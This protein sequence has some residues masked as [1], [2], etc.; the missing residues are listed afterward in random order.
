MTDKKTSYI[1][2][3][4]DN[5]KFKVNEI[6]MERFRSNSGSPIFCDKELKFIGCDSLNTVFSTRDTVIN[7]AKFM[8]TYPKK[9]LSTYIEIKP[10]TNKLYLQLGIIFD[11]K[12]LIDELIKNIGKIEDVR[13]A[14][15]MVYFS[16]V[17]CMGYFYGIQSLMKCAPDKDAILK[18][19][20]SDECNIQEIWISDLMEIYDKYSK[21]GVKQS[22]THIYSLDNDSD[23]ELVKKLVDC[24]IQIKDYHMKQVV[25][26]IM[27]VIEKKYIIIVDFTSNFISI[28]GNIRKIYNQ[29]V[30]LLKIKHVSN[31]KQEMFNFRKFIR[32]EHPDLQYSAFVDNIVPDTFYVLSDVV[33]DRF[34][35]IKEV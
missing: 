22:V 15:W 8:I 17:C 12:V 29:D 18:E 33:L 13:T 28:F 21:D 34:D 6:Q 16:S 11:V 4:P 2:K 30:F 35:S 3:F 32:F 9:P 26:M 1:F 23:F 24:K 19:L 10:L 20:S 5:K 14:T 31:G 27:M 25:Y 7:F